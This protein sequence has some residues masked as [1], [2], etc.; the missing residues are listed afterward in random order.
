MP[1]DKCVPNVSLLLFRRWNVGAL[2]AD[3]EES[4]DTTRLHESTPSNTTTT[5]VLSGVEAALLVVVGVVAAHLSNL[6]LLPVLVV[7]V[8][9]IVMIRWMNAAPART[10]EASSYLLDRYDQRGLLLADVQDIVGSIDGDRWEY[11]D[12]VRAVDWW[13]DNDLYPDYMTGLEYDRDA[14]RRPKGPGIR[15]RRSLRSRWSSMRY[16]AKRRLEGVMTRRPQLIDAVY[17]AGNQEV[18]RVV[19]A[20]A[21][22]EGFV[23]EHLDPHKHRAEITYS[24]NADALRP[25]ATGD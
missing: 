21:V 1:N 23:T 12:L 3:Q 20:R 10:R 13:F 18:A 14:K 8:A 6:A 15:V 5:Q 2:V 16:R 17:R 19:L 25:P 7:I 4:V 11:W 9:M 24:L 22:A